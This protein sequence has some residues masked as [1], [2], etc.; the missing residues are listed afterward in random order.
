MALLENK[1]LRDEN[2]KIFFKARKAENVNNA[3]ARTQN[4]NNANSNERPLYGLYPDGNGGWH[5]SSNS[6]CILM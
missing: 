3:P 6:D 1:Q 2:E 5:K 4:R